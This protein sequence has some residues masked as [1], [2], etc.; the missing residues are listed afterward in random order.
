[1]YIFGAPIESEGPGMVAAQKT[2]TAWLPFITPRLTA[3]TTG[4]ASCIGWRTISKHSVCGG[5]GGCCT[6]SPAVPFKDFF[7]HRKLFWYYISDILISFHISVVN[8]FTRCQSSTLEILIINLV[9][10]SLI[11]NTDKN[12]NWVN[13]HI[14]PFQSFRTA[15]E[16]AFMISSL[17][18]TGH[19]RF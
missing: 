19:F 9:P 1:M 6:P 7:L 15:G 16:P 3:H 11:K 5:V 10:Q 18:F 12:A 4:G 2:S 17:L 13:P 8:I 14:I